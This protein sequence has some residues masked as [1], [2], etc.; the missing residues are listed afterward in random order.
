MSAITITITINIITQTFLT[1]HHR[2]STVLYQD[3]NRSL[4]VSV[5]MGNPMEEDKSKAEA[6]RL[7]AGELG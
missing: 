3:F 1:L 6:R 7:F 5:N 4:S 2:F